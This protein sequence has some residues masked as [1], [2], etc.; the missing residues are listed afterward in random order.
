MTNACPKRCCADRRGREAAEGWPDAPGVGWPS[1]AFEN[2]DAPRALSR[3]TPEDVDPAAYARMKMALLCALRGNII[4]YNGEELG[5]GQ[6]EIPFELV[7]DPEA[8]KNWPLTLSRDGART[9]LPWAAEA[10]HAGFSDTDPWLPLGADHAAL[11]VD[12]QEADRS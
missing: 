9:P 8:R 6:V 12:R 7:K 10:A 2:H 5:L 4:L 11:A 3:W 1:W